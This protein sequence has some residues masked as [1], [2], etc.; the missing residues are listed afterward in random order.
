M[1]DVTT[2]SQNL[3]DLSFKKGLK[4]NGGLSFTN[5]FYKGS[6][7]LV[8]RDPYAF[9]LNGNLNVNLWGVSMPFSFMYS[10]T[11]KSYTQPF[12]RFKLDPRYKWVHL[13]IGTNVLEMSKYTLSDHLFTGVGVELTPGNWNISGMYGRFNKA[14]EYDPKI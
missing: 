7:S 6:D 3:D 4:V 9:Y 11:Q 14:I 8:L 2:T 5:N 12:N 13:L 10:N 1:A